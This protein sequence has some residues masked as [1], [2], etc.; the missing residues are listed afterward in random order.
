M[1]KRVHGVMEWLYSKENREKPYITFDR[2]CQTYDEQWLDHWHEKIYIA[3]TRYNTDFYYSI[4]KR[5][6]SNYYGRY[7]PTF[8]QMVE[9]TEV[10]LNFS[11][12]EHTFR[13]IID[14]LDQPKPGNWIVHD[15]K[16]SKRPKTERQA[17]NDIQ[18]ALYQIAVEQNFG[19]VNEISLSWHF[20]RMGSEV[21]ILHTR[22]QMDKLREKLVKMV[23][24]IINCMDDENN[25]LPKESIL[26]H[27]CY[28]WEECTA[29]VGP[30]PVM[31]AD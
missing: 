8:D 26:C 2:L 5:C 19:Q 1:G 18:L 13:G 31:R 6:L 29:K 9:D 14:R 3:D 15:Y 28:L 25:F 22:E 11:I 20:L 16:T 23:D 24:K 27:W 10:E 7:G 17:I 30:N 21:T 4:G 12:G